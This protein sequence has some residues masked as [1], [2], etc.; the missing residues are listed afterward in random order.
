MPSVWHGVGTLLN[1]DSAIWF[2]VLTMPT[3]LNRQIVDRDLSSEL[4]EGD[5]DAMFRF[6]GKI[7][8]QVE[9]Q[10]WAF[11]HIVERNAIAREVCAGLGVRLIDLEAILDTEALPDFREHFID[12]MHMRVRAYTLVARIIHGDG[13]AFAE[14]VQRWN[15]R[16]AM[17]P[18]G[19]K[20]VPILQRL[21]DWRLVAR[22]KVGLIYERTSP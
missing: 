14:A 9:G 17:L 16:W 18:A 4:V 12:I 8:Y 10:R 3:S 11:E 2:F 1:D 19:S 7:P 13:K 15:I 20:L 6:A 5:A 21:P 22:D